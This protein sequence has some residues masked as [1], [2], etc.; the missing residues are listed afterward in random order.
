M[1]ECVELGEMRDEEDEVEE[2]L[3]EADGE[4]ANLLL[5][6]PNFS[7]GPCPSELTLLAI[8]CPAREEDEEVDRAESGDAVNCRW[9][10][11][12]PSR[13]GAVP[14]GEMLA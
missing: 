5:Q 8:L 11:F 10:T 12:V 6:L 2:Q 14:P 9:D 4:F 13:P 7:G 1:T 3:D